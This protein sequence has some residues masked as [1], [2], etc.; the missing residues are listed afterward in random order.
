MILL[1]NAGV[2]PD[3]RTYTERCA[4]ITDDCFGDINALVIDL[5][6]K[7][8][9][10]S[11]DVLCV[12]GDATTGATDAEANSLLNIVQPLY[13]A[14]TNNAPAFAVDQGWTM[15][16][17]SQRYIKSGFSPVVGV[18]N[19]QEKNRMAAVY[20]RTIHNNTTTSARY[21]G[22]RDGG[23]GFFNLS[24]F[25]GFPGGLMYLHSSI[26]TTGDNSMQTAEPGFMACHLVESG[27][28]VA[29]VI[30]DD[31]MNNNQSSFVSSSPFVTNEIYIGANNNNGTADGFATVAQIAGWAIGSYDLWSMADFRA[32]MYNYFNARGTAV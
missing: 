6:S 3:V 17:A 28:N 22:H 14:S 13:D 16:A 20:V 29:T 10:S 19:L 18:T 32:A 30:Y 24:S 25:I 27:A 1:G 7:G 2:D 5:K 26:N 9:W 8:I 23:T 11:L 21:V 12:A 31:S 4:N 15:V